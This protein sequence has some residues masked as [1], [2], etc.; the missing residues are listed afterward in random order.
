MLLFIETDDDDD[1]G[2]GGVMTPAYMPVPS[3]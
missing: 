1:N 3:A 2:D